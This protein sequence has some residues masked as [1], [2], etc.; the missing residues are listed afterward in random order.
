MGKTLEAKLAELAPESRAR[1]ESR[2]VELIAEEASLRDLRKAM[3]KTQTQVARKLKI[4]QVAVSRLE[5][6]ADLMLSTLRGYLN[7]MGAELEVRA[8]FKGRPPVRLVG[9]DQIAPK[10]TKRPPA[11]KA[12]SGSTARPR[13]RSTRTSARA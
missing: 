6:R 12:P 2:A 4:G 5:Q 9:F 3:S 13:A 10:A 7:A 1:V 11:R 8:V